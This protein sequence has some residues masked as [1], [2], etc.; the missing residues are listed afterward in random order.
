MLREAPNERRQLLHRASSAP[1]VH[2]PHQTG[3]RKQ[4]IRDAQGRAMRK[5]RVQLTDVCNLRCF[6]CMPDNPRFLS[7][8]D[9]MS[10][11][12][13]EN[14]VR[15]L[16]P[17]GLTEI[18]LTGGEPTSRREFLEICERLSPLASERLGMTTNGL[19]PERLLNVLW[20]QTRLRYL[21]FSLDSFQESRFK[22][23][24]RH[25]DVKKV[26]RNIRAA[27]DLGFKVKINCIL[28]RDINLDEVMDFVSFSENEQVEVRFLEYMAVGPRHQDF[29]R[30][31]ISAKAVQEDICRRRTLA[32]L[33]SEPD[34]TAYRFATQSLAEGAYG[35]MRP[36][37]IG[38]IASESEPFCSRCSRLRLSATGVLRSCL[39]RNEGLSVRHVSA[40]DLEDTIRAV[41]SMKPVGRPARIVQPMNQIGG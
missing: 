17:F 1:R 26:L 39:F 24:T 12:E 40:A 33:P 20:Q 31:F 10:P 11:V 37:V 19:F 18:R 36:G 34:A 23:I 13:L 28:F 30:H 22:S 8:S 27:R 29:R 16:M 38:F 14:V 9:L 41:V 7:A 35:S 6:Y 15:A 2:R 32:P 3:A 21:N 25:G 5:L 4:L